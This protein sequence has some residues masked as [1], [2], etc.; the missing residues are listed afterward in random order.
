ME[1]G[2]NLRIIQGN[3]GHSSPRSTQ[4]YTHLTREVQAALTDPLNQLMQDL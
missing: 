2:V 4:I 1:I 3:L